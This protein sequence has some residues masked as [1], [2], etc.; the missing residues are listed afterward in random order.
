MAHINRSRPV[1]QLQ[2]QPIAD[3]LS[4][5]WEAYSLQHGCYLP[6][7][8]SRNLGPRQ[9]LGWSKLWLQTCA[10]AN[11]VL[12][13]ADAFLRS[14]HLM[15]IIVLG[16]CGHDTV[17]HTGSRFSSRQLG[18]RMSDDIRLK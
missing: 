14:L 15:K 7:G 18:C 10:R 8:P 2:S 3:H 12:R 4:W 11:G 16:M 6:S 5:G 17:I 1:L 9:V 13:I